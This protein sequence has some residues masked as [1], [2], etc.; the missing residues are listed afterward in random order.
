MCSKLKNVS[1]TDSSSIAGRFEFP[2]LKLL[3]SA[4]DTFFNLLC[5]V[6]TIAVQ[7]AGKT[8][9]ETATSVEAHVDSKSKSVLFIY[10]TMID[11][12][13]PQNSFLQ[14]SL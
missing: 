4:K 2:E 13:I 7:T 8:L 6:S 9:W 14:P 1:S 11:E 3:E 5:V 10:S 12:R